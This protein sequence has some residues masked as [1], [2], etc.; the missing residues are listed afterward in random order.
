MRVNDGGD[1]FA[2]VVDGKMHADLAGDLPGSGELSAVEIDDDIENMIETAIGT[3]T[4]RQ[5]RDIDSHRGYSIVLH[6]V[7]S[8]RERSH[9]I[10]SVPQRVTEPSITTL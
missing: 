10:I 6:V 4:S 9:G 3:A 5:G 2:A 1:I 7:F 8:L